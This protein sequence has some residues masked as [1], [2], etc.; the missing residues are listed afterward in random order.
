MA[1]IH[2]ALASLSALFQQSEKQIWTTLRRLLRHSCKLSPFHNPRTSAFVVFSFCLCLS[3]AVSIRLS[4]TPSAA[5]AEHAIAHS[6]SYSAASD[7]IDA[8]IVMDNV[9]QI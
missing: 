9:S 7:Y 4:L 1:Q 2:F 6:H 8:V 3:L 5:H